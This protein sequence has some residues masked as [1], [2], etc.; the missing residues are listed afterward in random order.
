[1]SLP[2]KN[3]TIVLDG[4]FAGQL[5]QRVKKEIDGDVLWS[6]R[7]LATDPESVIETHL[8]FL[9]AGSQ[10]IETNTYQASIPGFMKQLGL[11]EKDSYELIKKAVT[12]A[13]MACDRFESECVETKKR[14]CL[15]VLS[16][17]VQF[18]SYRKEKAS[19]RRVCWFIWSFV[20]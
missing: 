18:L 3:E 10:L 16:H 9:R 7:Y 17:V 2:G 13:K 15:S 5:S 8:D 6:S 4:G 12:L 14:K 20:T 1:M 19:H 11:S